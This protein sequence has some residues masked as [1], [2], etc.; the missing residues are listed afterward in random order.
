MFESEGARILKSVT[1][2]SSSKED[3]PARGPGTARLPLPPAHRDV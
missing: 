1:S 2:T 3:A